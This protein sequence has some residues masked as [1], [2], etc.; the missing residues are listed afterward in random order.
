MSN[1]RISTS[2]QNIDKAG[3]S[4]S[5]I[6]STLSSK[7]LKESS[8][9]KVEAQKAAKSPQ[10]IS[11]FLQNLGLKALLE[12]ASDYIFGRSLK[13]AKTPKQV[14]E[15]AI[16]FRQQ[17]RA[18]VQEGQT[19]KQ[20]QDGINAGAHEHGSTWNVLH[21]T[22][23]QNEHL[24][25]QKT[26]AGV[27]GDIL[28]VT[29]ISRFETPFEKGTHAAERF[30]SLS[31]AEDGN[32][33]KAFVQNGLQQL[34][35]SM[36]ALDRDAFIKSFN[37][38]SLSESP[39]KPILSW[40]QQSNSVVL[41][42]SNTLREYSSQTDNGAIISD[43]KIASLIEF[44]NNGS[45][46]EDFS[47]RVKG[48]LQNL[49]PGQSRTFMQALDEGFKQQFGDKLEI[50]QNEG[51]I[52]IKMELVSAAKSIQIPENLNFAELKTLVKAID[53][54]QTAS[55]PQELIANLDADLGKTIAHVLTKLVEAHFDLQQDIVKTLNASLPDS[56][57]DK[58]FT[59]SQS[60]LELH[61]M[62][63][64]KI[65]TRYDAL[66]VQSVLD[67]TINDLGSASTAPMRLELLSNLL[68]SSNSDFARLSPTD[69][70]VFRQKLNE[71]LKDKGIKISEDGEI[72][73][74]ATN[75][76][77][78]VR[79]TDSSGASIPIELE[80]FGNNVKTAYIKA[81]QSLKSQSPQS[82]E[83]LRKT[84]LAG[85]PNEAQSIILEKLQSELAA[86]SRTDKKEPTS[87]LN[88][89][90]QGNLVSQTNLA[91]TPDEIA[92][93][94]GSYVYVSES[95]QSFTLGDKTFSVPA[96]LSQS[97]AELFKSQI[98]TLLTLNAKQPPPSAKTA[99][100]ESE[101][102]KT[103]SS[104]FKRLAEPNRTQFLQ[105]VNDS[106]KLVYGES[107]K[108][109]PSKKF[110][111]SLALASSLNLKIGSINTI[112]IDEYGD[113]I[114]DTTPKSELLFRLGALETEVQT[115]LDPKVEEARVAA[116]KSGTALLLKSAIEQF[117]LDPQKVASLNIAP[118][119]IGSALLVY[120]AGPDVVASLGNKEA[121]NLGD[122][123]MIFA[124]APMFG[125]LETGE[126]KWENHKAELG[127]H[128][129][130]NF[131]IGTMISAALSKANALV[132]GAFSLAAI[133]LIW[134]TEFDTPEAKERNDKIASLYNSVDGLSALEVTRYSELMKQTLGP[135]IFD[136]SFMLATGGVGLPEGNALRAAVEANFAKFTKLPGLKL[137]L[138]EI[139]KTGSGLNQV[140]KNI[141]EHQGLKP[142][143]VACENSPVLKDGN[144]VDE[145]ISSILEARIFRDKDGN[146]KSLTEAA[147]SLGLQEEF[148]KLK[149]Q[150]KI[151][152]VLKHGYEMF[153]P[154]VYHKAGFA[155]PLTEKAMAKELQLTVQ[156]L[157]NLN[158]VQLR[159]HNITKIEAV[160]GR[161]PINWKYAGKYF[162]IKPEILED[163]KTKFPEYT[164]M[165]DKLKSGVRFNERGYPEF[166]PFALV[167]VKMEKG[168]T[169]RDKDFDFADEI[170]GSIA[171]GREFRKT[172]GW[173]WHHCED[174]KTLILV[175]TIIH[176]AVSHTG[177]IARI[178]K[179]LLHG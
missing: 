10:E 77:P 32:L 170:F 81:L 27:M 165:A 65:L 4:V 31:G 152:A 162:P 83:E 68:K 99:M 118:D 149:L 87:N 134:H 135:K 142:V 1:P 79:T 95:N 43:A 45:F 8:D 178:I 146:E 89:F 171:K 6:D 2:D 37:T 22:T 97:E 107:F 145:L 85:L 168:F 50:T 75:E 86:L 179:E 63:N 21:G 121:K 136:D 60:R 29:T 25:L 72:T 78:K 82:L 35:S 92:A 122:R 126:N 61:D 161:L 51:K 40:D 137:A 144:N 74:I 143:L 41:N 140:F 15:K 105:E 13:D 133:G 163:F 154:S 115:N 47:S 11:K 12:G 103:V 166:E 110:P 158:E 71:Y 30:L 156:E 151:D 66:S 159:F 155:Q 17:V 91:S 54:I 164:E 106:L 73:T 141:F 67:T 9:P 138:S 173:T 129:I 48:E 90:A 148:K 44:T 93:V 127:L 55:S 84:I 108:L 18:G 160:N 14:S 125:A 26:V 57:S 38:K 5:A 176:D 175:P 33:R 132:T 102:A 174:G 52:E 88:N 177:G 24:T 46:I 116:F 147:K 114:I 109:I 20:V 139:A 100:R 113:T 58:F 76:L 94:E 104:I 123:I 112:P 3:R 130:T 98:S 153:F 124:L 36:S 49:T 111:D 96:V 131:S 150:E 64:G 59:Y 19:F 39:D 117:E 56:C 120:L 119:D 167:T 157:R 28:D 62:S 53:A 80:K 42:D 101:L 7:L 23:E 128:G 70:T 34:L 169:Y 69:Q 16:E 172:A